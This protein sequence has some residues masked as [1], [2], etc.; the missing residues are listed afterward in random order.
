MVVTTSDPHNLS[1]SGQ[2]SD[3]LLTGI[4][5]TCDLDNGGS[6]HVYPR[7]TDPA[8]CGTPVLAVNSATE[9]E[10]NVGTSTVA[11][12]YQSGESH[13]PFSLHQE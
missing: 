4:G 1:T 13:N 11:T 5:M 7:T 2:K 3:V 10:V 9:F 8:Y 12:Y 6:T